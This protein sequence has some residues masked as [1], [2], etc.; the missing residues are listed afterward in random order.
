MKAKDP[1]CRGDE[2]PVPL[3]VAIALVC[4]KQV[5]DDGVVR[6][7]IGS[8][9]LGHIPIEKQRQKPGRSQGELNVQ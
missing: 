4:Q 7:Q 9:V 6:W 1:S 2:Y 3:V 5:V 8:D